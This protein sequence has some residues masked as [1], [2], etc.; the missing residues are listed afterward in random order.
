MAT[1]TKPAEPRGAKTSVAS[2]I[3]RF[4]KSNRAEA[5]VLQFRPLF[6]KQSPYQRAW[7]KP[8]SSGDVQKL[9]HIEAPVSAFVFCNVR[10]RFA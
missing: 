10:R 9:Q 7:L 4:G 5:G 3:P 2:A 8:N 1:I 6:A